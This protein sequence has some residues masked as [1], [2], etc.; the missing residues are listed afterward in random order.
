MKAVTV[1]SDLCLI[2]MFHILFSLYVQKLMFLIR[3]TQLDLSCLRP[4]FSICMI[5][6]TFGKDQLSGTSPF[7]SGSSSP[8][9][10][11]AQIETF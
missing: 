7:I 1:S 9:I 3:F 5:L 2:K 4:V 8:D 6:L 10:G 11:S